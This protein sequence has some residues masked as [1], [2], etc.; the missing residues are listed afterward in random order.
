VRQKHSRKIKPFGASRS[1]NKKQVKINNRRIKMT[2]NSWH[3]SI[4]TLNVSGLNALIK[5]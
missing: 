5:T 3:L 4:L 2:G 1:V